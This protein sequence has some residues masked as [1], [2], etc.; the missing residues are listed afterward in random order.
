M[1]MCG[2]SF[3]IGADSFKQEPIELD[4]IKLFQSTLSGTKI[5]ND[6]KNKI[7]WMTEFVKIEKMV[8]A[9]LNR[10]NPRDCVGNK[11]KSSTCNQ[12]SYLT[13][14]GDENY[15]YTGSWT[16]TSTQT[17]TYILKKKI[18]VV[19][20][21]F[22]PWSNFDDKSFMNM[23]GSDLKLSA[24]EILALVK[25]F[26]GNTTIEFKNDFAKALW[27]DIVK[28]LSINSFM[29]YA[30]LSFNLSNNNA[31]SETEFDKWY[32]NDIGGFEINGGVPTFK[33]KGNDW[34]A[35]FENPK[36]R[37]SYKGGKLD[38]AIN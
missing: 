22:S 36:I 1:T 2:M 27:L 8:W 10:N 7:D 37:D 15:V 20:N 33:N 11:K 24:T 31:V 9:H 21:Y 38:G 29:M 23:A 3:L 34:G 16:D 6:K 32:K 30:P 13:Q 18:H 25:S 17:G 19:N 4:Y 12:E 14:G 35:A 5:A 28:M 26:H